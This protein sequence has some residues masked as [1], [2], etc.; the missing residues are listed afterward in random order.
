MG[1]AV[2]VLRPQAIDL[3]HELRRRI[4]DDTLGVFA[5]CWNQV[6]AGEEA[7]AKLLY[8]IGTSRLFA[9][10]MHAAIKGPSSAGK[11]EIRK[12]MLRFFPPEEVI[13][14]TTLSEKALIYEP[15][16]FEAQAAPRE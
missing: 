5:Q 13:S 7:N 9:K 2:A 11:S 15:R 4:G 12:Q 10:P 14:F 16:S 1:N 6:M 3:F 8:L